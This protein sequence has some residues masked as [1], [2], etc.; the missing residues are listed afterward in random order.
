MPKRYKVETNYEV[1]FE[2]EVVEERKDEI[3][4]KDARDGRIYRVKLINGTDNKAL[5]EVNGSL[6]VIQVLPHQ[7]ILVDLTPLMVKKVKPSAA[8]EEKRVP[9]PVGEEGVITAPITGKIVDIKVAPGAEVKEGDVIAL[10]ESMKMIV[11]VKSPLS[12]I[13]EEIYVSKGA[14]V[15]KGDRIMRLRPRKG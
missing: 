4:L 14:S 5:V 9:M 6:H 7:G 12:G 3:V 15:N 8:K 11:E 1:E 13:V 2:L 10:M